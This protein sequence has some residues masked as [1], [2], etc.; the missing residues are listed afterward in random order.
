MAQHNDNNNDGLSREKQK[1]W[2]KVGYA[3]YMIDIML[4]VTRRDPAFLWRHTTF[5]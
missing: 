2:G 1:H 3:Y 5:N 4:I